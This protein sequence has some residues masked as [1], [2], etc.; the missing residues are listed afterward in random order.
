MSAAADVC[1]VRAYRS[2]G[3]TLSSQ[4]TTL[5]RKLVTMTVSATESARLATTPATA[6]LALWRWCMARRSA[7][8]TSAWPGDGQAASSANTAAGTSAT[9]PNRIAA[10]EA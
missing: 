4:L 7:S 1:A 5:P 10:T 9:P 3:S 2:A 8:S 6:A